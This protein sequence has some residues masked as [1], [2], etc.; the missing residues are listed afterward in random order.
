MIQMDS[1]NFATAYT[2]TTAMIGHLTAAISGPAPLFALAAV[3]T[4][5]LVAAIRC[6]RTRQLAELA[7]TDAVTGLGNRRRLDHDLEASKAD[8]PVAVVMIDIDQFKRFNDDHG[9]AAGDEVLRQVAGVLRSQVRHSDVVYRYGGEEFC[10]LLAGT[11]TIEAGEVAERIRV[12]VSRVALAFEHPLTVSIGVALGTGASAAPTLR[13]A[14]DALLK[15]KNEGRDRV[16]LAAQP[17]LDM[18]R[19]ELR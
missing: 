16:T 2:D 19:I 17:L 13:R 9:H 8:S 15:S 10:I 1:F 7:L 4:M 3:P 11:T 6:R 5:V 12:A 14:D 18:K